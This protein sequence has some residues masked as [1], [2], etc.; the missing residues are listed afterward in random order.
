MTSFSNLVVE[1]IFATP[2]AMLNIVGD[3][4][5]T[6]EKAKE[7]NWDITD[8]V[9]I[10]PGYNL[11]KDYPLL[12]E[13][14]LEAFSFLKNNWLG[15]S[16]VDFSIV[17]S[18]MTMVEP[19]AIGNNHRHYN[20]MFTGVYYPFAGEYSPLDI[21]RT[22][23]EPNS[24]LV[25]RDQDSIFTM[26]SCSIQPYQSLVLFFPSHIM[27]R[28]TRNRGEVNRHSVAFNLYPCGDL[29][30]GTDSSAYTYARPINNEP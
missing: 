23:L 7:F 24:F 21:S 27:H 14:L 10:T 26:A 29:N 18:W 11:L 4:S 30:T 9:G 15:M 28:I 6:E 19:N 5:L 25:P 17:S 16:G 12:E 1:P 8:G 22:G 13:Q 20:S 2:L 3:P